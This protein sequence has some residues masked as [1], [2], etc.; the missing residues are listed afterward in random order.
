MGCLKEILA[1]DIKC[2]DVEIMENEDQNGKLLKEVE[3]SFLSKVKLLKKTNEVLVKGL[4]IVARVDS[5]MIIYTIIWMCKIKC[6][7]IYVGL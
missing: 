4:T 5:M 6:L 1:A 7:I 2:I 3:T